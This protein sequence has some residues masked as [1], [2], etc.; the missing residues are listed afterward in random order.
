MLLSVVVGPAAWGA[1]IFT[2]NILIQELRYVGR[3]RKK[4]PYALNCNSRRIESPWPEA[5]ALKGLGL[6]G[7]T[8]RFWGKMPGD[9][10]EDVD[11]AAAGAARG[12]ALEKKKSTGSC[13]P[14]SCT[15]R[16]LYAN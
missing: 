9:A 6:I 1:V 4:F 2:P 15:H 13:T 3:F 8:H 5:F 12:D 14:D 7:E 16:L 11:R 10:V